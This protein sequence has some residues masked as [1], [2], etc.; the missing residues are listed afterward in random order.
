MKDKLVGRKSAFFY[1]VST[2]RVRKETLDPFVG[3]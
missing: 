1:V 2:S 3:L